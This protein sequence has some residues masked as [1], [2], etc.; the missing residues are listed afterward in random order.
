MHGRSQHRGLPL[1]TVSYTHLANQE[2]KREEQPRPA[3]KTITEE[4]WKAALEQA[5]VNFPLQ[6]LSLIHISRK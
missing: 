4:D 6:A 3:T 1:P 5:A 2:E